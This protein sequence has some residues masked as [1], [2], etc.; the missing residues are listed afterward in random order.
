MKKH[1][2]GYFISKSVLLGLI[3]S[4]VL[5][6]LIP[7]LRQNSGLALRLFT[8]QDYVPERISF[9]DAVRISAPAVIDIV[10]SSIDAPAFPYQQR[11]ERISLGSGVIMNEEGYILTCYHV[12]RNAETISVRL[13]DGR[14]LEAQQVGQ[15]AYTDLAVLKVESDNL[16]VIPQ[17]PEITNRVGDLVLAIGNPYNVGQTITQGVISATGRNGLS[18]NANGYASFIQMDATLNEGNSGGALIDSNGYL[19]GINNANFKTLDSRR[20]VKDV[21]G[22]FF[23]VPYELAKKVMDSIIANGRVIRGFIGINGYEQREA[24]GTNTYSGILVTA[25]E[26]MGPA[27]KAGIQADDILTRIEEEDIDNIHQ[28]LD[29]VAET[30]P[31]SVLHFEVLRDNQRLQIPV[32]IGELRAN[33]N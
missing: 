32:T 3:V 22:I 24:N 26:P 7:D 33:P 17:Q 10:S 8:Q 6:I 27:N 16:A 2:W 31:G 9:H 1:S 4:F 21:A 18:T 15:D 20:R 12:I 25:V 23:A 13:N 30:Q 5:L 28:V 11:Q 14:I 29:R 19:V